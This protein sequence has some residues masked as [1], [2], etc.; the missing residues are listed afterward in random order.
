MRVKLRS[1]AGQVRAEMFGPS[2]DQVRG[3]VRVRYGS[4]S[5]VTSSPRDVGARVSQVRLKLIP[6]P[7]RK[8][9]MGEPIR[10]CSTR[11]PLEISPVGGGC[12]ILVKPEQHL[13]RGT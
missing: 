6:G 8:P 4:G 1:G 9:T 12:H 3:S 11:H 7:C 10:R 2:A 13:V 5:G